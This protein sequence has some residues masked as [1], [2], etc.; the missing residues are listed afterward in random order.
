MYNEVLFSVHMKLLCSANREFHVLVWMLVA[1]LEQFCSFNAHIMSTH[2]GHCSAYYQRIILGIAVHCSAYYE[3]AS[4]ALQC[5]LLS[6]HRGHFSAYYWALPCILWVLILGTAVLIMSTLL[7]HFS[8]YYWVLILGISAHIIGHC[9]AYYEY[10]SW[11]L[12]CILLSTHRGHF[13]SPAPHLLSSY[14]FPFVFL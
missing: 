5:I 8:A 10:S 11:A 4:W 3:Y 2:L 9:S 7:G 12:Q 13:S 14:L 1:V 6:T